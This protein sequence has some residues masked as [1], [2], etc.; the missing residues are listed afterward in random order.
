MV[1]AVRRD[2][3]GICEESEGKEMTRQEHSLEMGW[4]LT[5]YLDAVKAEM[6]AIHRRERAQDNYEKALDKL[7]A[8]VPA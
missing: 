5:A 8:E 7:L 6:E 2:W 4:R 3:C 1:S